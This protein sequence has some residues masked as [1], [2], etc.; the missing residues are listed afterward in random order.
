MQLLAAIKQN[1][2]RRLVT[3]LV[4]S[5][6]QKRIPTACFQFLATCGDRQCRRVKKKRQDPQGRRGK[7]PDRPEAPRL[8][9]TLQ[10]KVLRRRRSRLRKHMEI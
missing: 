10:A 6:R 2:F 1:T 7:P 3:I 9:S 5:A 8:R 4:R